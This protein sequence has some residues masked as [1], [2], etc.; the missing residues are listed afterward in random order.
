MGISENS[1]YSIPIEGT[2]SFI[3]HSSGMRAQATLRPDFM[4]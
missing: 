4:L 3:P 1:K 2:A